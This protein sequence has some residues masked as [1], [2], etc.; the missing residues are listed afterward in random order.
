MFGKKKIEINAIQDSDL[1]EA[2]KQ[3][4][5]YNDLIEGKI[6][7]VSCDTVMTENNI[8]VIQSQVINGVA[9]L[10]FYCERIDCVDEFKRKLNE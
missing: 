2:L 5:Q 3:T 10:T 4:R 1:A 7:C 8:G 6:H 9:N